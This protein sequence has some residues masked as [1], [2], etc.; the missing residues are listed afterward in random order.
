MMFVLS[1][2]K[3]DAAVSIARARI[4]KILDDAWGR[5]EAHTDNSVADELHVDVRV[6]TDLPRRR[7]VPVD[8]RSASVI[9]TMG[10]A[11]RHW[12]APGAIA[13]AVTTIAVPAAA[14]SNATNQGHDRVSAA[15]PNV[16]AAG[17]F[18]ILFGLAVFADGP[19]QNEPDAFAS[20]GL[21]QY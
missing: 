9:R 20:S 15:G 10:R 2:R 7:L 1:S 12:L 14:H 13:I 11:I 17:E 3:S 18:G 4:I 5:A 8:A 19:R 16:R 21:Q 6:V